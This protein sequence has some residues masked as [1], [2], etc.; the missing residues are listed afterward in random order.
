MSGTDK[1]KVLYL[2]LLLFNRVYEKAQGISCAYC[3][4]FAGS[5]EYFFLTFCSLLPHLTCCL[6]A[7]LSS[8]LAQRRFFCLAKEDLLAV[9]L[10]DS[11]SKQN[12]LYLRH[13]IFGIQK[14]DQPFWKI[15][16][17]EEVH[18]SATL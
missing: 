2:L 4:L 17:V 3:A 15:E 5:T 13:G 8:L 9:L 1:Q 16:E 7:V 18:F 6:M 12:P 14:N 11:N 10:I